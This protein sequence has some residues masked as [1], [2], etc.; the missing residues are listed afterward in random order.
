MQRKTM[1]QVTATAITVFGGLIVAGSMQLS[2]GWGD[3]GPQSGYFPFRLGV[4]LCLTGT[5]LFLQA[6]KMGGNEVFAS[7]EQFLRT[8]VLF[9]P[10]LLLVV[11]MTWL[12]CYVTSGIYMYYMARRH[13]G[14][15]HWRA[16]CLALAIV[17]AMYGLFDWWFRVPLAKGPVEAWLGVY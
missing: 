11:A 9:F 15:A 6:A 12:G 10:T 3:A 16:A 7:R 4:L 13:G 5:L 1:E 8:L 17:L 2:I 14:F